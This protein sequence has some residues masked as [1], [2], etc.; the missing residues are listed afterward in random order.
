MWILENVA[1]TNGIVRIELMGGCRS[2]EELN[3]LQ[4]RLSGL[5]SI[6]ITEEHFADAGMK[7]FRLRRQGITV[8]VTDLLIA[9]SAQL[10]DHTLV[11]AYSDFEA[12]RSVFPMSTINKVEE[13]KAWRPTRRIRPG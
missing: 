7:H 1:S 6:T 4:E 8:A 12:I 13:I 10:A 9:T 2:D 5:E 11:H 3:A